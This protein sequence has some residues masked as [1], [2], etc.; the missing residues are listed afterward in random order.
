MIAETRLQASL[1]RLLR[2]RGP[3]LSF[4][5]ATP[6]KEWLHFAVHGPEVDA[7]VNFSVVTRDP[8]SARDRDAARVGRLAVLVHTDRWQGNIERCADTALAVRRNGTRLVLGEGRLELRNGRFFLEATLARTGLALGLELEPITSPVQIRDFA[9]DG[10]PPM[11]WLV[12]PRLLA[13][14][15]V[16]HR[17]G[18]V[19]LDRAPAYHD[20]N[21]GRFVWGANF[22]WEWGYALPRDPRVPWSLVFVRISDRARLSDFVSGLFVWFGST[23]ERAFGANELE[24]EHEGLLRQERLLKVPGVLGLLSPGTDTD[25]PRRLVVRARRGSDRVEAA[26]EA[27]TVAQILVPHERDPGL[28]AIQEVKGR[29]CVRGAIAGTALAFESPSVFEFLR[30]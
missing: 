4:D 12:V 21:F 16:R 18:T 22:T 17:G 24:I 6:H 7:V 10:G 9:L 25:V 3:G 5:A 23:P 11:S 19:W 29:V 8:T 1:D 28:T 20:H 26:F 2:V 14:G 27:H 30:A 13:T 15:W